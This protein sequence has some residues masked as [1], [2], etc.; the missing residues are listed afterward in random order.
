MTDSLLS[1]RVEAAGTTDRFVWVIMELRT[2]EDAIE[3]AASLRSYK[4]PSE[5]LHS[6]E[7]VLCGMTL[8]PTRDDDRL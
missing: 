8:T 7:T 3:I 5:A 6:A 1:I 2:E 4:K